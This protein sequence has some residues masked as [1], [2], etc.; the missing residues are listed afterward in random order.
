MSYK[1]TNVKYALMKG[2]VDNVVRE[3]RLSQSQEFLNQSLAFIEAKEQGKR[4][5]EVFGGNFANSG[6]QSHCL[7]AAQER[8]AAGWQ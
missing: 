7:S 8:G 5:N 2:F 1:H 3:E 6:A 4:S